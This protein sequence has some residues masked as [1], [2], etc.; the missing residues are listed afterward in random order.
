[1]KETIKNTVKTKEALVTAVVMVLAALLT[2]KFPDL[3]GY[4]QLTA[5]LSIIVTTLLSFVLGY[6]SGNK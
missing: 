2:D 5:I 4:D 3:A 6:R 1:M